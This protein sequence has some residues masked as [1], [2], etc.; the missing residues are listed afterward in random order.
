MSTLTRKYRIT[1]AP[2]MS[3]VPSTGNTLYRP[4]R[5]VSWPA[6]SEAVMIPATSGSMRKP[7]SIGDAPRT[8]CRNCGS[9]AI[10]PNIAMP[11]ITPTTVTS[12]N[13][14]LRKRRSGRRAS[15]P[16]QRSTSTKSSRPMPPI[17]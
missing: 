2:S 1:S 17:T 11:T 3:S 6:V 13:T 4:V 9:T 7:L 12:E 5:E 14:L 8:I 15:S 16:Y 10:P